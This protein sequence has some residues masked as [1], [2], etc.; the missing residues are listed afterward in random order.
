[1]VSSNLAEITTELNDSTI[2]N[3][4]SVVSNLK[5]VTDKMNGTD[6]TIGLLLNDDKVYNHVDQTILSLDSLFVDI[7]ANPKRYINVKVF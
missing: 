3:V 1:M 5:T 2:N 4:N 6:S 7:K